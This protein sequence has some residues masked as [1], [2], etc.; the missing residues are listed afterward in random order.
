MD[1]YG[2]LKTTIRFDE[3]R[4]KSG[5]RVHVRIGRAEREATVSDGSFAVASGELAF[6]PGSSGWPTR[7]GGEVRWME[8]FLRGGNAWESF[9]CPS[10]GNQ[11]EVEEVKMVASR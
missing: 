7:D 5:A 8:L 4:M 10:V 1:G 2:N 9:G 3:E 11:I 6:A